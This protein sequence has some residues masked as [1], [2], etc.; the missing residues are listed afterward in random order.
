MF[1][2]ISGSEKIENSNSIDPKFT[3]LTDDPASCDASSLN[4]N[5]LDKGASAIIP[6]LETSKQLGGQ[7]LSP[8]EVN[9]CISSIMFS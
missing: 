5:Y 6:T 1:E 9:V 8:N 7:L 3:R 2:K 4:K